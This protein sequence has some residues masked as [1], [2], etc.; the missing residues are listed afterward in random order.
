MR[1]KVKTISGT[2]LTIFLCIIF[3]CVFVQ[4]KQQNE[5]EAILLLTTDYVFNEKWSH[6]LDGSLPMFRTSDSVFKGQNI[7][8]A[9]IASNYLLDKNQKADILYTVKI[10]RPDQSLYFSKENI[11]LVNKPI[12]NKDY[13]QLSESVVSFHF[14]EDDVWGTYKIQVEV[15]DKVAGKTKKIES[16]LILTQIPGYDAFQVKDE[17]EFVEWLNTYYQSPRPERALSYYI[18]YAKSNLPENDTDFWVAF[19]PFQEIFKNN[20]YLSSQIINCYPSQDLEIRLYLLYLLV[21]ANIDAPDFFEQLDV[22]EKEVY[23]ELKDTAMV[24]IYGTIKAGYQLDMLWG[25]FYASGSYQPILK[26]IKTL[27]YARYQGSLDKFDASKATVED[28]QNAIYDAIY[29]ALIWSL[30]SNY[31]NHKLVSDYCNWAYLHEN[32]SDLQRSELKKILEK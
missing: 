19:S 21:Y 18:F 8:I 31:K 26:L 30:S 14:K 10:F 7:F 22:D 2:S 3:F 4:C 29:G 32:L 5:P 11:L 20:A 28:R 9:P 24:D 15:T 25:N 12:E 17:N 13:L 23:L 27:D 16:K 6:T 1:R